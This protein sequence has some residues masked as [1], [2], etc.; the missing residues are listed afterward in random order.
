MTVS[1]QRID[2]L[3]SVKPE[4]HV[5][6]AADG[7]GYTLVDLDRGVYYALNETAGYVWTML[8]R[9]APPDTIV[10]AL[11]AEFNMDADTCAADVH[12]LLA[13]LHDW[14]LLSAV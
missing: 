7:S 2:S 1:T 8:L 6:L 5:V 12:H 4:P 11:A 10:S 9:G 13:Q 14:R 3:M